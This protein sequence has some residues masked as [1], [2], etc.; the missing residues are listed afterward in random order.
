M[1][2]AIGDDWR[3]AHG[4]EKELAARQEPLGRGRVVADDN[5]SNVLITET[6]RHVAG[7]EVGRDPELPALGNDVAAGQIFVKPQLEVVKPQRNFSALLVNNFEERLSN[8]S[9]FS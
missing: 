6:S 5:S 7:E 1:R 4:V 8:Q 2:G 9:F 3:R